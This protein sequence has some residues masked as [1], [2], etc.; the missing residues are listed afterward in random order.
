MDRVISEDALER[1]LEYVRRNGSEL[2][3]A[4]AAHATGAVSGDDV[5]VHPVAPPK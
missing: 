3:L 2:M 5:L 1:G 4:L